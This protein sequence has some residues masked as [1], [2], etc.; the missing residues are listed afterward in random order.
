VIRV[1]VILLLICAALLSA[2]GNLGY[3]AQAVGGHLDI[4]ARASDIDALLTHAQLTPALRRQLQRHQQLLAFA[5]GHLQLP[6]NGSYQRYA[7]LDRPYATWTLVATDEFSITPM[8]KC[9]P[10]FGCLS[11]RGYFKQADAEAEASRLRHSGMDVSISGSS[12]YSSLGWS[13]DPLLSSMLMQSIPG[14]AETLLHELAHQKRYVRHDTA[15][16][17]AFASTVASQGTQRWLL[18]QGLHQERAAY[19][20]ANKQREAFRHLIGQTRETLKRLYQQPMDTRQMRRQKA[21]VFARMQQ[22][23]RQLREQRDMAAGHDN[24][25]RQDLNNAHLALVATYQQLLPDFARLLERCDGNLTRFYQAVEL[26]GQVPA[27]QRNERLKR[28]DCAPEQG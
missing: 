26:L 17:E 20:R 25:M 15:F 8:R 27:H 13:K 10:L 19:L 1:D 4:H 7:D 9:F 28:Q 22:Q 3:Y 14:L 23:Y 24:W 18:Q 11:Y 16:N 12:A 5:E 2:C 21:A 6:A